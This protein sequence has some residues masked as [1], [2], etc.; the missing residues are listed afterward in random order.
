MKSF[1]TLALG[2][3]P[4]SRGVPRRGGRSGIRV[5]PD[6]EDLHPISPMAS[7]SPSYSSSEQEYLAPQGTYQTFRLR[8]PSRLVRPEVVVN[9]SVY[10][11]EEVPGD[12]EST[13]PVSASV[14]GSHILLGDMNG[15]VYRAHRPEEIQAQ[16]AQVQQAPAREDSGYEASVQEVLP[17]TNLIRAR[18]GTYIHVQPEP[19]EMVQEAEG[20][21]IWLDSPNSSKGEQP[22]SPSNPA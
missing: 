14:Q 6:M 11:S 5:D 4:R 3:M 16:A 10:I 22:A 19:G 12:P 2:N 20:W 1:R 9:F 13:S 7:A 15:L 17:P 8:F 18:V 21:V